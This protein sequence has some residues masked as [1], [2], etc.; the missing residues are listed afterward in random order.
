MDRAGGSGGGGAAAEVTPPTPVTDRGHGLPLLVPSAS[1]FGALGSRA[2]Q[3]PLR[4]PP[5]SS[6][7]G[8]AVTFSLK[9]GRGNQ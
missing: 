2:Q 9:R 1:D 5:A 7:R 3:S 6:S 4:A 8:K